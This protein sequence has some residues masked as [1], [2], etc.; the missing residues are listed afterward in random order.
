MRF[1]CVDPPHDGEIGSRDRP[2]QIINTTAADP[3]LPRLPRNRQ[4]VDMVDHRFALGNS[5]AQSRIGAERP[6]Q[7]IIHQRQLA[8]LGMQRLYVDRRLHRSSSH[9]RSK[10]TGGTFQKLRA[11]GRDLVRV[12]VE[13]LRQL[14]QRLLPSAAFPTMLRIA[15]TLGCSALHGCQRHS[16]LECR[17]MAPARSLR[18]HLSCSTAILVTFRQTLHLTHCPDLPSHFYAAIDNLDMAA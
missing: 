1:P 11:P 16:R 3:Q 9:V 7:K 17:T 15:G 8:D 6:G 4:R 10:N 2:W 18:H 12:N 14:G 13:L 5:P